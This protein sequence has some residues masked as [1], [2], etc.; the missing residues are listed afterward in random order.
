MSMIEYNLMR[1]KK[2]VPAPRATDSVA[3]RDAQR[4][5]RERDIFRRIRN[6]D[7]CMVARQLATLLRA[8][9]PLLPALSA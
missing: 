6:K 1:G 4:G 7:V 2:S 5:V 9:M 8:G 3:P